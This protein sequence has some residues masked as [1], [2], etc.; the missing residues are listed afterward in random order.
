MPV[1]KWKKGESFIKKSKYPNNSW[2][3]PGKGLK[4]QLLQLPLLQNILFEVDVSLVDRI[5]LWIPVENRQFQLATVMTGI[6]IFL[7]ITTAVFWS[8]LTQSRLTPIQLTGILGEGVEI[9]TANTKSWIPL[10]L[11]QKINPGMELKTSEFWQG[12]YNPWEIRK[13]LDESINGN[14]NL[15]KSFH[16]DRP[17]KRGY[18]CL[19][20]SIGKSV[21]CKNTGWYD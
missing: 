14:E 7:L 6:T 3:L 2:I 13:N 20:P 16:S 17:D 4:I 21:F 18:L 12:V 8:I 11:R 5:K 19:R 9:R 10:N 1:E 15:F